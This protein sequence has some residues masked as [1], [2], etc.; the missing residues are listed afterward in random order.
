MSLAR[1]HF[2]K[3]RAK[4]AAEMAAEFG[5][6]KDLSAYELQLSQLNS[7]RS[8]LKQYQSTETKAQLKRELLPTYMPYVNGILEADKSVQDAV[9]MEIMVWCIDTEDYKKALEMAAFALR[10]KMIMPDRFDRKTAVVVTEEISNAYLRK[11]KSSAEVDITVLQ[12]L[13]KIVNN[14]ELPIEVLDMPN[15]VQAKLLVALGKAEL[16]LIQAEINAANILDDLLPESIQAKAQQAHDYL[17]RA[18]QLDDRC[19]GKQDLKVVTT[20]LKKAT[21]SNKQAAADQKSE[22]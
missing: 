16:K 3:Y 14:E 6:M 5:T 8:R 18:V 10:H 20:L 4:A 2:Q 12:E 1:K 17:D 15:Q 13:H 7:D 22:S 21:Q 11:L 9:F 19:N